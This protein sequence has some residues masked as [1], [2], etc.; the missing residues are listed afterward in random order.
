MAIQIIGVASSSESSTSRPV[1]ELPRVLMAVA[2][3]YPSLAVASN[4]QGTVIVEVQILADGAVTKAV[5]VVDGHV[6][7]RDAASNAARQWRFAPAEEMFRTLQLTF[8]FTLMPKETPAERLTSVF[9]P[10]YQI[11]ARH[12]R[13]EPVTD[14]AAAHA[15]R[16]RT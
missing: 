16:T 1:I 7:L 11:E 13:F 5:R 8:L 15:N 6:L 9:M 4:T 2:P 14:K 12:V 10:P 3:I